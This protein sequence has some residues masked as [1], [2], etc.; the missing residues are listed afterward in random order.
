MRPR[1]RTTPPNEVSPNRPCFWGVWSACLCMKSKELGTM[2]LAQYRRLAWI[3]FINNLEANDLSVPRRVHA[4]RPLQYTT[5]PFHASNVMPFTHSQSMWRING[6]IVLMT[7]RGHCRSSRVH[8]CPSTSESV[9]L[10]MPCPNTVPIHYYTNVYKN[11]DSRP[12]YSLANRLHLAESW[13]AHVTGMSPSIQHLLI[14]CAR[15]GVG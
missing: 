8:G 1:I 13:R 14:M 7:R 5:F 15:A 2:N 11:I 3:A 4:R 10:K 6:G 12:N 9:F